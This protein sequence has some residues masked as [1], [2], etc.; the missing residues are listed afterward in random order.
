M[1]QHFTHDSV[2]LLLQD[3][4]EPGEETV[5]EESAEEQEE[6]PQPLTQLITCLQRAAAIQPSATL[7]ADFLYISYA[8][9]MSL[10]SRAGLQAGS[11]LYSTEEYLFYFF[12]GGGDK[13]WVL[14]SLWRFFYNSKL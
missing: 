5:P 8:E 1:C 9:I 13:F 3:S 2:L 7:E 6:S 14:E 11:K 4:K 12:F 10:V